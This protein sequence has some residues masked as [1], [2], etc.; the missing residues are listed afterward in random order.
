MR[1]SNTSLPM[2]VQIMSCS[3]DVEILLFVVDLIWEILLYARDAFLGLCIWNWIFLL[4][5]DLV[6]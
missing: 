5:M 6:F 1:I 3:F 2:Q 4:D